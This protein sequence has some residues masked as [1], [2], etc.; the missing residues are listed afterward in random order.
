MNSPSVKFTYEVVGI[1]F[2][3]ANFN[4]GIINDKVLCDVDLYS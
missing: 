2:S 1:S 3:K 4:A